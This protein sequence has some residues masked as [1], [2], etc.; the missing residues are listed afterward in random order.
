MARL[1]PGALL[2]AALCRTGESTKI[3][4]SRTED[5]AKSC[6]RQVMKEKRDKLNQRIT[7]QVES[8]FTRYGEYLEYEAI[9]VNIK[10]HGASNIQ[11]KYLISNDIY[12]QLKP[13]KNAFSIYCSWQPAFSI[14]M[15]ISYVTC[16]ER[17]V[18]NT[19]RARATASYT[20]IDFITIWIK[21]YEKQGTLTTEDL[22]LQLDIR[23]E[24]STPGTV[25]AAL[26]QV[27]EKGFD[28]I[29]TRLSAQLKDWFAE[30]VVPF[31][32]TELID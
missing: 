30:D 6:I 26:R 21:P 12:K 3:C 17:G 15:D 11:L 7:D 24:R 18:C 2:L 8:N 20:A 29:T 9:Y 27:A 5:L 1:L 22:K 4:N 23:N 10:V 13:P 16:D 31:L 14:Q 28:D 25:K 32:S 19:Y